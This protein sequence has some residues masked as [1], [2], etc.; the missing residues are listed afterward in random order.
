MMATEDTVGV[1]TRA[2]TEAHGKLKRN[3][4]RTT[5]KNEAKEQSKIWEKLHEIQ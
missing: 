2:M 4:L 1:Q 3:R 5:T